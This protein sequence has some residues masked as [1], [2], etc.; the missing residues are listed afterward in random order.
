MSKVFL[1]TNILV[2]SLDQSDPRKKERCRDLLKHLASERNGVISTQ[3]LQ[4]FY[5]AST[6]KLGADPLIIKD[7]L[8]SFERF[9]TVVLTPM[10]IREAV[11]CA[12][13]NRISFW[14]SLIIVAAE[15]AHCET[16]WS[17]DLNDGQVIRGVRIH[18]PLLQET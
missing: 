7:I 4:E 15:S 16:L 10:L 13:L 14:D 18:N 1:D 9:E 8:R 5:V 6:V 2:Y 17:E 12:V 11:D 3:V